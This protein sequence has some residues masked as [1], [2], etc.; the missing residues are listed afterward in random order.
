MQVLVLDPRRTHQGGSE[1]C[2]MRIGPTPDHR[3]W[4]CFDCG[5]EI[6]W[7]QLDVSVEPNCRCAGDGH[8]IGCPLS[9]FLKGVQVG[10]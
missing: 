1:D 8:D 5:L 9:E 4:V 6:M 3:R 10:Q 7:T 2:L